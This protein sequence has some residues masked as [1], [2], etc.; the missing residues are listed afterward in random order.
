METLGEYLRSRRWKE[1]RYL[2]RDLARAAG[3][4]PGHLSELEANKSKTTAPTLRRLAALLELD[5]EELIERA[6]RE[7]RLTD[8]APSRGLRVEE[9][10]GE[11]PDRQPEPPAR[12]EPTA[13][14]LTVGEA[15]EVLGLSQRTV[16]RLIQIGKLKPSRRRAGGGRNPCLFVSA[17]AVKRYEP[18]DFVRA[19]QRG[20]K[21]VPEG[22][23]SIAGFA[24]AVGLTVPTLYRRIHEGVVVTVK[25][26]T[27]RYIPAEE[28]ERYARE[29]NPNL[30]LA[31][32]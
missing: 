23:F 26:G 27:R 19:S 8:K 13:P 4:S 17:T 31:S 30:E 28:L 3:I 22:Y 7:G 20:P 9:V 1:H 32:V 5:P 6:R 15:A 18:S 10:A 24:A 25:V 14:W 2:Q 12:P 29:I 16:R 21:P 11:R